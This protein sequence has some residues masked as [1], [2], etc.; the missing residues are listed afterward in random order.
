M[1]FKHKKLNKLTNLNVGLIPDGNR[2]WAKKNNIDLERAYW[3]TMQKIG[4]CI[5]FL[6]EHGAS[7]VSVYLLSKDNIDR[8]RSDLKAVVNSEIRFFEEIIPKLK[9][10][11]SLMVFHAGEKKLLPEMYNASLKKTCDFGN[12]LGDP[13]PRLYLCVAYDPFHEL[14]TVVEKK[15]TKPCDIIRYLNV[16]LELDIVIRTG[17]DLRL[18]GFLP[19]QIKYAELFFEP[20][21]FPEISRERIT[22]IIE[23]FHKRKRT[24]GK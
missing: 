24:F 13:F 16:P 10:K 22:E 12:G 8:A 18:S 7:T 5:D 23:Y 21:Y 14:V 2:R 6:F 4:E 20:Y 9:H 15:I 1:G 11:Y 19:L 3:I 17:G